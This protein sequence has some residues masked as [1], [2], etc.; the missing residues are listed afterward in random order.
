MEVRVIVPFRR[1]ATPVVWSDG[2]VQTE[3]DE[4]VHLFESVPG[5]CQCG[6]RL[7]ESLEPA[8]AEDGGSH[9]SETEPS[10]AS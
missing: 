7:W 9:R 8:P 1:R 2:R 6:E 3:C 5:R 4:H 10:D